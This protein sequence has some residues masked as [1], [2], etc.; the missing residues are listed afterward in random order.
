MGLDMYLEARRFISNWRDEDKPLQEAVNAAI[1][2]RG[3]MNVNTVI[4]QAAYWRKANQ[5][6]KWFVDNV[7]DCKDDC[8]TY[9]VSQEQ[10]K[11]LRD[12]CQRVLENHS[13]AKSLLPS[14]GGF[15]FGST[16][17][18]QGYYDDLK[19]TVEQLDKLLDPKYQCWEF[20]YHHYKSR[21][22]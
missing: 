12:V 13:L 6:H 14:Q 9:Y 19:D 3:D 1:P 15:F 21:C 8:G 16:D 5:I 20:S 2:D 10:L 4:C 11:S 22:I 17:Y 18:D 7:Q